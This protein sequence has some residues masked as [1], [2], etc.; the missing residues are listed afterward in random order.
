MWINKRKLEIRVLW[1]VRPCQLVKIYWFWE[2]LKLTETLVNIYTTKQVVISMMTGCGSTA[3]RLPAT[4]NIV[5]ALYHKLYTQ[6]NAPED[7]RNHRPKHVELIGIINKPLLLHIVG[8]LYYLYQWCTV[9]QISKKSQRSTTYNMGIRS[10]EPS[11]QFIDRSRRTRAC[12]AIRK[13]VRNSMHLQGHLWHELDFVHR[14]VQRTWK[15]R[16][17]LWKKIYDALFCFN[18]CNLSDG[19]CIVRP[20][21]LLLKDSSHPKDNCYV[22]CVGPFGGWDSLALSG[23]NIEIWFRCVGFKNCCGI[24]SGWLLKSLAGLL[25]DLELNLWPHRNV[26]LLVY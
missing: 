5:G 13:I 24:Y 26:K 15:I 23:L 10:Q 9:K 3:S 12:W 18:G 2:A 21:L 11:V 4:G 17:L 25:Y 8:C 20:Y 22:P 19:C 6:S 14:N 1:D 7:G 16:F